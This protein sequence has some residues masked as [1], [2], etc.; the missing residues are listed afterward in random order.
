MENTEAREALEGIITDENVTATA[1]Q[2]AKGLFEDY[3]WH[4][5]RIELNG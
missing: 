1:Q 2:Y 4:L 3:M 5:A